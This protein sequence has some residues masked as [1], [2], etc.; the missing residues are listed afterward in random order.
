MRTVIAFILGLICGGA[1]G[2]MITAI[3]LEGKE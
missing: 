1:L 3:L 2:V